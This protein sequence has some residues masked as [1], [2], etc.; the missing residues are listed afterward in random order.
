MTTVPT[1]RYVVLPLNARHVR[2]CPTTDRPHPTPAPLKTLRADNCFAS[3]H[4]LDVLR[5]VLNAYIEQ[6]GLVAE[7]KSWEEA[8]HMLP[9]RWVEMS[10]EVDQDIGE[11]Q[12]KIDLLNAAHNKRLMVSFDDERESSQDREIDI[13][14]RDVTNLFKKAQGKLS[15]IFN[16]RYALLA[17]SLFPPPSSFIFSRLT[18]FPCLP[19]PCLPL[20][21]LPFPSVLPDTMSHPQACSATMPGK[22]LPR[23]AFA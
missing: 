11:I 16:K 6:V 14:T 5:G 22:Y 10:D 3:V 12:R 2:W 21:C 1:A 19:F 4:R 8:S 18:L 17:R 9:P 20:P 7:G 13:L 23:W 15:R